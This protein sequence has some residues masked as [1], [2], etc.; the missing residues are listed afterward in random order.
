MTYGQLWLPVF[1]VQTI[2]TSTYMDLTDKPIVRKAAFVTL[3][4]TRPT[5][6]I[7]NMIARVQRRETNVD[8]GSTVYSYLSTLAT[9][10]LPGLRTM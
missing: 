1:K 4:D 9:A 10:E 3:M 5:S 7:L 2:L 6:A 8:V